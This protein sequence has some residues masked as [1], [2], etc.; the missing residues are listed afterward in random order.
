MWGLRAAAPGLTAVYAGRIAI[1]CAVFALG[2]AAALAGV[3]AFR[4]ART[5]V[6]PLHPEKA[7]AVVDSG[8]FRFS[9]NPMYLGMLL[10][11]VA[12]AIYLANPVTLA[13]PVLF[14]LY[15]NRFQI[16]PEERA[17]SGIFGGPYREYL[18]RV[19]RWIC[20]RGR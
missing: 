15:M 20:A 5:T 7:T 19:R 4:R 3:V 16:G 14:V 9:R 11:L 8:I 18:G 1:A 12:W 2:I 17:L 10:A 6:N 13:G